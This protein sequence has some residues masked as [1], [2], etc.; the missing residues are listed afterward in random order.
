MSEEKKGGTLLVTGATL[1][2]LVICL[3][4]AM[5]YKTRGSEGSSEFEAFAPDAGSSFDKS[6]AS[7]VV[8]DKKPAAASGSDA[9]NSKGS[10]PSDGA[11]DVREDTIAGPDAKAG[12]PASEPKNQPALDARLPAPT[13]DKDDIQRGIKTITPYVKACYEQ[14][15]TDFPDA[16]G[17]VVI[18]FDIV[19]E[20]DE[21][22]VELSELAE[23]KTTLFDT[24]LHD[25]IL[26]SIGDVKFEKPN[27]QGKVHVRY[28][29][30]FDNEPEE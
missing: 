17:R 24:G 20:G 13:L 19:G 14:T 2:L 28:P 3:I 12:T 30:Q 25:C 18:A 22:R 10:E 9:P 26:E 5:M 11:A 7:V 1:V 6:G 8:D 23:D 4:A 21:G 29:F 15:L 27:G 16:A